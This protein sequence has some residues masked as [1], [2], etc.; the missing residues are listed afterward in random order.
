MPR[1]A[2][3]KDQSEADKGA[4]TE[5]KVVKAGRKKKDPSESKDSKKTRNNVKEPEQDL[6]NTEENDT[7][8]ENDPDYKKAMELRNI[9]DE[10]VKK[11][12]KKITELQIGYE[13]EGSNYLELLDKLTSMN[14]N[15]VDTTNKIAG[16]L[17]AILDNNKVVSLRNDKDRIAEDKRQEELLYAMNVLFNVVIMNIDEESRVKRSPESIG[18]VADLHFSLRALVKNYAMYDHFCNVYSDISDNLEKK[19]NEFK[20]IREE[21][22]NDIESMY[23]EEGIARICKFRVDVSNVNKEA[24]MYNI[25]VFQL[26][27]MKA[28]MDTR[29]KNI[30][31]RISNLLDNFEM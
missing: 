28:L 4:G 17:T 1:K 30:L 9:S 14:I 10:I 7:D 8:I 31:I 26:I 20:K 19:C 11:N 23:T 13:L 5:V 16:D 3:K 2:V 18:L 27:A 6:S 24:I 22:I 21:L 25:N 29:R 12:F 15:D